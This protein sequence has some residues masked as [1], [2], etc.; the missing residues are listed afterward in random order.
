M[1]TRRKLRNRLPPS[2]WLDGAAIGARIWSQTE[3]TFSSQ[4]VEAIT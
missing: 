1:H 3:S 4:E 2:H